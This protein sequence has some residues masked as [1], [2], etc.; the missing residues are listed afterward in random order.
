MNTLSARTILIIFICTCV[1]AP[2]ASSYGQTGSKKVK[3]YMASI[4]TIAQKKRIKGV[5]E[6]VRDSS[7]LVFTAKERI[8]IPA[9]S[10]QEI[11][12][13]RKGAIGRGALAGGLTGF[14][15]GLIIGLASGDD[16]CDPNSW[17]IMPM[18]AEEK[19]LAAGTA[20]GISGAVL[21]II[22][23]SVSRAE[24]IAINGDQ[25]VFHDHVLTMRTYALPK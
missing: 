2:Y 8:R 14:G 25:K 9:S 5:L 19:G 4:S 24:K 12:I 7:V 1:L 3:V 10:I 6:E 20:L 21:G 16:K 11:K 15:L 17:C 22:I 13:K 18:T 23:G